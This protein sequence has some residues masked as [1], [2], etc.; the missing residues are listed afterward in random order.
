MHKNIHVYVSGESRNLQTEGAPI[1]AIIYTHHSWHFALEGSEGMLPRKI[2]KSKA[3]N[4][5]F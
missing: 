1:F 5:T 4:D 2:M 3:S